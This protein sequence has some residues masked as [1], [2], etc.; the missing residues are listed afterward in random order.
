MSK[1]YLILTIVFYFWLSACTQ[2]GAEHQHDHSTEAGQGAEHPD[3]D[4]SDPH[5]SHESSEH[6]HDAAYH[7]ETI[8]T[9]TFHE[10]A[11]TSGELLS[12][13]KDESVLVAPASG[14]VELANAGILEGRPV[15][16]DQ[17]LFRISGNGVAEDNPSV[18][19]KKARAVFEQTRSDYERAAEL[20]VDK[21]ITQKEY[22]QH[23]TE[24]TTARAEYETL[25]E[26]FSEGQGAVRSPIRGWIRDIFVREGDY[27]QAGERMATVIRKD[28]ILL[29]AE[30]SQKHASR[31]NE[32]FAA[33]FRTPEGKV[34]TTES[35][36]GQVLSRGK[37]MSEQSFYIPV[38]FEMD[39]HP[40]LIPGS[41]VHVYLL[42][43]E[44]TDVIA[45]PKEAFI[46]EQGNFFVFVK[47]NGDFVKRAVVPGIS[48]GES[49]LVKKGIRPGERVVTHGAYHVKLNQTSSAIPH[50]HSH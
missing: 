5:S 37:A 17:L 22:L 24:Y 48:D 1:V 2:S 12:M 35:L 50:G 29:K 8:Q 43:K 19:L 33:K 9:T 16:N 39:N 38:Y 14:V 25:Q 7:V 32:F 40:E 49:M 3:H 11:R 18:K 20:Y 30:V 36:N 34:Y 15:G 27:V 47:Q 28:K 45:L 21:L 41:F 44:K 46:E 26:H 42:G 6:E 10:V 4:S 31:L 23:K 13:K